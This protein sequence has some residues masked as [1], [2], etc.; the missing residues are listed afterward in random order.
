[1]KPLYNIN[2]ILLFFICGTMIGA[3]LCYNAAIVPSYKNPA[4]HVNRK[5]PS[6]NRRLPVNV[7]SR[8]LSE[9]TQVGLLHGNGAVLPLLGRRTY[10]GSHKWNYYTVS[11]DHVSIKIPLSRG[12]R[13]CTEQ[14]GC[15]ELYDDDTIFV[16]EYNSKF[17]VKLYDKSPRYI[18][19]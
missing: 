6:R 9:Y 12:N 13:D 17:T 15:E 19:Y 3:A 8:G 2:T 4:P 5:Q 7:R 16:H 1:M 10:T 18:P 14:S 11:S